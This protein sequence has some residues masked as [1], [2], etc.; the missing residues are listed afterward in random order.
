MRPI[1]TISDFVNG[2]VDDD[3]LATN[4]GFSELKGIDIK[5]ELGVAK[6]ASSFPTQLAGIGNVNKFVN[7]DVDTR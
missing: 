6:C 3:T 1:V 4:S 2:I 7:W 5:S